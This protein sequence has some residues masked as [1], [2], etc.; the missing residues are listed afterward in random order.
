[1]EYVNVLSII[2]DSDDKTTKEFSSLF[3]D[4]PTQFFVDSDLLS[5]TPILNKT[6]DGRFISVSKFDDIIKV[7]KPLSLHQMIAIL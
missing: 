1:M 6:S 2:M 7:K 3:E 4:L 5:D